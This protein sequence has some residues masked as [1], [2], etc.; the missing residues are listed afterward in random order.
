MKTT[1]PASSRRHPLA[2]LGMILAAASLSPGAFAQSYRAV[3][4]QPVLPLSTATTIDGAT[5]AGYAAT[6]NAFTAT[7]ATLWDGTNQ[8]DL[9]PAFVG[10]PTTGVAGSSAVQGSAAGLQVGWA[11]GPGSNNRSVPLTWTGSALSATPL[12]IPFANAGGRALATDG[13][14]IVGYG[15]PLVQEDASIGPAHALLWDRSTGSV[16]D[17]GEGT[18]YGVAGGQQV[19]YAL[20]GTQNAALWRGT[21]KSLIN[22]HPK[23]AVLS[24]A[25]GTD[26][27]TQVGYVGYDIRVRVEAAKGKK[28][29]R[30]NYA[31][32]WSG[33]V[34]SALNLHPYP[35]THSYAMA[36]NGSW[37]VGHA[38]DD[39]RINTP[40]Y[41]H[42]IAWDAGYQPT[43]LQAFLPARYVGSQA[44]AV[45]ARG[46]VAGVA[47]AADGTRRAIYWQIQ[48]GN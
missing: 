4:L 33:S 8:V 1:P 31:M 35:F 29:K 27:V 24:I 48:P 46:N 9:H 15:S 28:Y 12:T 45:D 19:G 39:A 5:V 3:E 25:N 10:S 43:D 16:V 17:L 36:V 26:S 42:A 22:L 44:L 21:A 2:G 13:P 18:A 41:N 6:S 34:G 38:S 23:G 30:F 20:K 40:A 32:A 11:F 7:H 37:I 47:L 14:Q